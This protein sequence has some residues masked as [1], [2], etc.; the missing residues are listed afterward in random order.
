M[1][2]ELD[3]HH[4]TMQEASQKGDGNKIAELSQAIHRCQSGIDRL[5]DDLE[6]LTTV[7]ETESA[8]FDE[9]FAELEQL[10]T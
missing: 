5:F 4:H 3:E 8:C 10:E 9:K 7:L 1:E 2:A 6:R